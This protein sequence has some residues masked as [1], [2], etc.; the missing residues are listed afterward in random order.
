MFVCNRG[1]QKTGMVLLFR[2]ASSLSLVC[3]LMFVLFVS[4][5]MV[6]VACDMA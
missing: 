1:V 6:L 4:L 3:M 5:R 2:I